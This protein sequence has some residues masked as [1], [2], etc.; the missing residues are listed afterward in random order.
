M[1]PY[2]R[3]MSFMKPSTFMTAG[4]LG[5]HQ[6]LDTTE[7]SQGFRKCGIVPLNRDTVLGMLPPSKGSKELPVF[8]NEAAA[9]ALDTS[10]KQYMESIRQ[11]VKPNARKKEPKYQYFLVKVFR[12][13]TFQQ[14][15]L[16]KKVNVQ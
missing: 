10:F 7:P 12:L 11:S 13:Q 16:L 9:K 8:S 1:E 14:R 6:T 5:D 3:H 4:E 15:V 2:S